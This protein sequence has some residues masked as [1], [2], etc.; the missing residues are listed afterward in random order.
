MTLLAAL[1]G[2]ASAAESSC[3]TYSCTIAEGGGCIPW[4][5][6]RDGTNNCDENGP[7]HSDET[8]GVI[9]FCP[10]RTGQNAQAVTFLTFSADAGRSY[11]SRSKQQS[12]EHRVRPC[13][14]TWRFDSDSDRA[15]ASSCL[16]PGY[17]CSAPLFPCRAYIAVLSVAAPLLHG[18]ALL[19]ACCR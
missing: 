12:L 11:A 6:L 19:L 16:R 7:T 5:Q 14:D 3:T 2:R 15:P 4:S 8:V 10:E 13:L 1:L 18:L 17:M 9:D